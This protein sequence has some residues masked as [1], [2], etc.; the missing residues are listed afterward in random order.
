M[1]TTDSRATGKRRKKIGEI[2][3]DAGLI[4]EEI[5][6]KAIDIQKIEKVRLGRIL[7]DMKAVDDIAI[8]KALSNQLKIPYVRISGIN[9]SKDI[10]SLVPPDMARNYQVIP[11]KTVD[12]KLIIAMTNPL[13]QYALKD[14]RLVTQMPVEI[15]IAPEDDIL[16][17]IK[18]YYPKGGIEKEFG[19]DDINQ[20]SIEIVKASEEPEK[21]IADILSI[22]ESP[23]V[24]RFT[25]AVFADALKLNASDIH[26]EPQKNSLL[27]RYRLDGVLKE[28]MRTDKHIHAPFVS[29]L[30]I[31][32]N[33]DISIK[34][35]P[36]DGRSQ[37]KY[38]NK[39]YDLRVSTIPTSYGETVTIRILN[40]DMGKFQVENLGIPLKNSDNFIE[41]ISRPQG[42][43][44]VTG[45]TGSGK[46]ST[47]YAC[48]N[49]LNTAEVKII[50]VE[51]PVE[52]DIAGIDQ[53]QIN[54]KAGITFATGLRSILR[55]DPDIV[56]VGEI[57]DSETAS[58]AF[59]AAQT[60]HLVLSTLHTN[61]APSAI[62]RLFD[63]G[64]EPY[65]CVASLNI[66]M[67][68]RLVRKICEECKT[69]EVPPAQLMK[70]I[71]KKFSDAVFYKGYGCESCRYTGYKGRIAIFE[72]LTFPQKIKKMITSN[73]DLPD[74]TTAALSTGY[75]SLFY[76]GIEK[77]AKGLTTV[78]EVF[79]IAAPEKKDE[80]N[81]ERAFNKPIKNHSEQISEYLKNVTVLFVDDDEKFLKLFKQLLENKGFI[82]ITA[83]NGVEA[84]RLAIRVRPDIIITD[85]IMPEMDGI[86]LIKKLKANLETRQIPI[87]MITA[88]QDADSE[89]KVFDAGADD[90]LIKPVDSKRLI[91]RV[92]RVI[93]N[94]NIC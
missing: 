87:I 29:R 68:Q 47:L 59:Q 33:I 42:I 88:L 66:V 23:P 19:F 86:N 11:L 76:D 45:P 51:D 85:Y 60:G 90:F 5:L 38:N 43:I 49:K 26:I 61:D 69:P 77:A 50:T 4:D 55:Q 52:Y 63:L 40:P 21:D 92:K 74:L 65:L 2:L 46:S 57:R 83:T 14:L 41:A 62:I 9:L 7:I 89:V 58:I 34:R 78:E 71:P 10:I 16:E 72:L 1:E 31:L 80:L 3:I 15:M 20:A 30:K 64:I 53:V 44:L 35:K 70:Q 32:S 39:T 6:K 54:E 37:I 75:S 28:A 24:V 81:P 84:L 12:K 79:R 13:E 27:I 36:Q 94:K 73:I 67:G 56:M 22:T 25:N 93:D 18:K 17:N 82:V 48:L 91:A 8:A